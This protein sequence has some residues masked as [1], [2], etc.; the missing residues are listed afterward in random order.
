MAATQPDSE[1]DPDAW[2][3]DTVHGMRFHTPDL[4]DPNRKVG[5]WARTLVLDIDH[6]VDQAGP[7]GRPRVVPADLIFRDIHDAEI[8][9]GWGNPRC[10]AGA[11]EP[12]INQIIRRPDAAGTL[13]QWRV[14]LSPPADG[15]IAF[16]A[17]ALAFAP[18]RLSRNSDS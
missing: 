6:L 7:G 13:Y 8:S 14:V 17:R 1:H 9:I 2:R 16:Y 3:G 12:T 15:E 4:I 5:D 11:Y 18:R 10:P